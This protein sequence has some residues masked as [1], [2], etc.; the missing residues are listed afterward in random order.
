MTVLEG[1]TQ[2]SLARS[3]E[4]AEARLRAADSHASELGLVLGEIGKALGFRLGENNTEQRLRSPAERRMRY[5]DQLLAHIQAGAG[6]ADHAACD[7]QWSAWH[8]IAVGQEREC[9]RC[10]LVELD[11]WVEDIKTCYC[12]KLGVTGSQV[13]ATKRFKQVG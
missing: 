12:R 11:D 2:P 9:D 7:H 3:W 13:S 8:R 5:A 4:D 6:K 10:H 1:Q